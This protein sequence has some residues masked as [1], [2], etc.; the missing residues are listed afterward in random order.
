MNQPEQIVFVDESG[1][2]NG[3]VESKLESPMANTRL[4]PGFNMKLLAVVLARHS[5]TAKHAIPCSI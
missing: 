1:Q 4:Y 5:T 3:E 2:A